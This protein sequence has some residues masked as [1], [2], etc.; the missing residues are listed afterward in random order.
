MNVRVCQHK[1]SNVKPNDNRMAMNGEQRHMR[2]QC[3]YN[4]MWRCVRETI[5]C[6]GK[7]ISITYCECVFVALGIK[8]VMCMHRIIL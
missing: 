7:A 4:V 5:L 2:R 1:F 6:S 3:T 8:H